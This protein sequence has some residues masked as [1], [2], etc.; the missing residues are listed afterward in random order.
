MVVLY[1]VEDVSSCLTSRFF[2]VET[3]L[4]EREEAILK[5]PLSGFA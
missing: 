5:V 1:K 4:R 2:W 3:W